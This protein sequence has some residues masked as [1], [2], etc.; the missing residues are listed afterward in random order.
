MQLTTKNHIYSNFSLDDLFNTLFDVSVVLSDS[1]V[2]ILC[3]EELIAASLFY[4]L[5]QDAMSMHVSSCNCTRRKFLPH[6]LSTF[7]YIISGWL[8]AFA[9]PRQ[10]G[11]VTF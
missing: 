3:T 1:C 5:L 6:T 2:E 9:V 10:E 11:T 7:P 8:G 4:N